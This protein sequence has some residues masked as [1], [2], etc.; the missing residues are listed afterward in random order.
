MPCRYAGGTRLIIYLGPSDQLA[1]DVSLLCNATRDLLNF[2]CQNSKDGHFVLKRKR[3]YFPLF[4]LAWLE[5]STIQ[6]GLQS[7]RWTQEIRGESSIES[8]G[9]TQSRRC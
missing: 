9:T 7:D 8:S 6:A 1:K 5:R 4:D 3:F 2:A